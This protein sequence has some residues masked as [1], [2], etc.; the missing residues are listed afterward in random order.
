MILG[1]EHVIVDAEDDRA[2][3]VLGRRRDNDLPGPGLKVVNEPAGG[4]L[5]AA[6]FARWGR[7][8]PLRR[9]PPAF[10]VLSAGLFVYFY[11]I[12]AASPLGHDQAF[13][14]WMWF[15]PSRML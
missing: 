11:P 3:G 2:V 13:N 8:G 9:L 15:E 5:L 1:F 4:A 14:R 6:A 12:I 10:I 7:S